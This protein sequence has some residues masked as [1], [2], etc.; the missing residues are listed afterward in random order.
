M[1]PTSENLQA[2][3]SFTALDGSTYR[4]LPSS[5][6]SALYRYEM[7]FSV[8]TIERVLS[9]LFSTIQ[10]RLQAMVQTGKRNTTI[11]TI[12]YEPFVRINYTKLEPI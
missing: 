9:T 10:T 1:A 11:D 5:Q 8:I 2:S 7:A 3:L 4:L 12:Q 6:Q